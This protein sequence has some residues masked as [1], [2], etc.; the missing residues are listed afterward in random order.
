[1][2]TYYLGVNDDS[3]QDLQRKILTRKKEHIELIEKAPVPEIH[4]LERIWLFR[5]ELNRLFV[6]LNDAFYTSLECSVSH[7]DNFV[8]LFRFTHDLPRAEVIRTIKLATR[9]SFYRIDFAKSE[10]RQR[11]CTSDRG[12]PYTYMIL[13]ARDADYTEVIK[14]DAYSSNCT[15]RKEL[16]EVEVYDCD[17]STLF[18]ERATTS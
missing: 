1:M 9:E 15:R 13:T 6:E 7:R 17:S 2:S 8:F 12:S 5:K 14:I 11:I 10:E 4:T 3:P 18:E 16:R